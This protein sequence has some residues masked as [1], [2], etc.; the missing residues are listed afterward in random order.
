[1]WWLRLFLIVI[2]S[3]FLLLFAAGQLGLLA[4]KPAQEALGV[5]DGRLA[6]PA[7]TPNSVT[8]QADLY[9]DHPQKDHARIAPLRYSGSG[10]AAMARLAATVRAMER[11]RIVVEQSDYIHAEIQTRWLRFTDDMEFWLDPSAGVIQVRSASRLGK[12]DLGANR[13]HIEAIRARFASN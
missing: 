1:M 3:A 11:T 4:G 12:G 2:V 10:Q 9:P 7:L 5:R 13:E 6:A 8:S